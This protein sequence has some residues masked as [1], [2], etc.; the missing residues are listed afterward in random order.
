[1]KQISN[2]YMPQQNGMAEYAYCN[3]V[4]MARSML[5]AQKLNKLFWAKAVV[6]ATYI[7][8]QYPTRALAS[9]T[10]KEVWSGWRLW[11]IRMHVFG[12]ITLILVPV[13]N[14]DTLYA[15]GI[16]SLFL[17]YY[18]GT[19]VYKRRQHIDVQQSSKLYKRRQPF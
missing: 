1:M 13:E 14:K 19:K 12:C 18:E 5:R 7:C 3:V 16:E 15:N 10:F 17:G 6:N 8:N 4:E 2:S 11:I 9:I